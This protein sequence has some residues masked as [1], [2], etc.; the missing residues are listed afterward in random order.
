M[1]RPKAA[2]CHEAGHAVARVYVGVRATDTRVFENGSGYSDGT[3]ESWRSTNPGVGAI[4]DLL[5]VSM[6]GI[7]AEARATMRSLVRLQYSHGLKNYA[8]ATCLV[9]WLATLWRARQTRR[10]EDLVASGKSA[11]ILLA[12]LSAHH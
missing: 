6:A 3:L 12:Q 5:L 1:T 7:H 8:L 10:K 9:M 11:R 4:W 2:A